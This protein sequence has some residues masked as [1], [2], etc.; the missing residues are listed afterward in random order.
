MMN[1]R[2]TIEKRIANECLG[3]IV[4]TLEAVSDEGDTRVI[5]VG[6]GCE[7][8][9]YT[10]ANLQLAYR[11]RSKERELLPTGC[12]RPSPEICCEYCGD[13]SEQVMKRCGGLDSM[14]VTWDKEEGGVYFS[15]LSCYHDDEYWDADEPLL[16]PRCHSC[17]GCGIHR[18]LFDRPDMRLIPACICLQDSKGVTA[19]N[20]YF[21][22]D[23]MG[24]QNRE[25]GLEK[26]V[27]E[28]ITKIQTLING[29]CDEIVVPL[30]EPETPRRRLFED[31]EETITDE[32]MRWAE[33]LNSDEEFEEIYEDEYENEELPENNTEKATELKEAVK[34]VGEKI[35]DLQGQLKEGDYLEIMNLLQKVTNKV[36]SL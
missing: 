27:I 10:R 14:C 32:A 21:C 3:D 9:D 5:S 7:V 12:T 1:Y 4:S 36:N 33:I 22:D 24:K 35:F 17:I 28:R 15:C 6:S 30:G 13:G 34:E 16:V 19:T 11:V 18:D 20:Y 2:G 29:Q 25:G 26:M 8:F 23:C 31:D